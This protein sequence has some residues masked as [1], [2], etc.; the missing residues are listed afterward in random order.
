MSAFLKYSK[1]NRK[2]LIR[3]NPAL[4]N[5]DIS[6]LL[7]AMWRNAPPEEKDVYRK[8]ELQLSKQSFI[9]CM[10]I[11]YIQRKLTYPFHVDTYASGNIYKVATAEWKMNQQKEAMEKTL[12]ESKEPAEQHQTNSTFPSQQLHSRINAGPSDYPGGELCSLA[13][14][15]VISMQHHQSD[16]TIY[17]H[18]N[19]LSNSLVTP[20]R[21]PLS[22]GK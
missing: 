9:L 3:E 15:P 16:K 11:F 7:G 22:N 14:L 5:T 18:E 21:E 2:R 6:K 10:G 1:D 12:H 19:D 8:E 17:P 20:R 13:P 4:S